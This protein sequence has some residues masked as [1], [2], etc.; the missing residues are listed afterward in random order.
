MRWGLERVACGWLGLLCAHRAFAAFLRHRPPF[1]IEAPVHLAH[2]LAVE[3]ARRARPHRAEKPQC[4]CTQ[5]QKLRSPASSPNRN[6]QE[7]ACSRALSGPPPLAHRVL[8]EGNSSTTDARE[9]RQLAGVHAKHHARVPQQHK[10]VGAHLRLAGRP[11][12]CAQSLSKLAT[13]HDWGRARWSGLNALACGSTQ[14]Q[15]L[16]A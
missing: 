4:G 1:V 7:L 5:Q 3:P 10:P 16:C 14:E 9:H 13:Q 12:S 6:L 8:W 11:P 2:M 15:G